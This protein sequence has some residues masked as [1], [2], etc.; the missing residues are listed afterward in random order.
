MPPF[1]P[2]VPFEYETISLP[3]TDGDFSVYFI[4][5]IPYKLLIFER[6]EASFNAALRVI[7]EILDE[8]SKLATR[9][10]KDSKISVTGFEETQSASLFLQDYLNF[11]LNPGKYKISAL[12]SD[13]NSTIE[14]PVKP[15]ELNLL[16]SEDKPVLHPLVVH[17]REIICDERKNFIL[18]NSG[19]SIPFSS[20]KFHLIIPVADTSIKEIDVVIESNDEVIISTT[21]KESYV[22]PVGIAECEKQLSV[23]T[24]EQTIP[25]RNFVVRNVNE[26]LNEGDVLLKVLNKEKSIEEKFKSKITWFNKPVSFIDPEKAIEFLSFIEPDSLVNGLLKSKKSD[27]PKVLNEY[28]MKFDPTPETAYNEIMVEFYNRVDFAMREF[29]AIEKSNGAKTDRGKVYIKF[30]K[31]DKVERSSNPLG[32]IIETWIYLNP[33]RKFSFLDKKGTGNFTLIES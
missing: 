30:G 2:Q 19:G 22:I 1:V 12:V 26:K 6:S 28:W 11:R 15:S 27:Y 18:A 10:I 24:D 14:L 4:Y 8:D 13:M 5:K 29:R 31:P 20:D 17:S 3:G 9:D 16:K 32:Q 21:V 33:S 25:L 23:T 7:V